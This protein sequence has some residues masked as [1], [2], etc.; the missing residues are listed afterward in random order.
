MNYKPDYDTTIRTKTV[1]TKENTLHR[2]GIDWSYPFDDPENTAYM[3]C[4]DEEKRNRVE[5]LKEWLRE[6]E[7]GGDCYVSN[8]GGWPRIWARVLGTGMASASPYWK[9][10][11]GVIVVSPLGGSEWYDWMLLTGFRTAE[12]AKYEDA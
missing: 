8:Y 9:P 6:C 12:E 4:N 11:P 5:K 1:T 7:K 10:R 3:C 2:Q